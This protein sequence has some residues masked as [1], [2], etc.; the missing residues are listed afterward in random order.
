MA[1][2]PV[3]VPEAEKKKEQVAPKAVEV[4]VIPVPVALTKM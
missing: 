1:A 3:T 4:A 2:H